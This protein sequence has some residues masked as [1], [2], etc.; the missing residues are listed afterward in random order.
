LVY[1][2]DD[3]P[4]LAMKVSLLLRTKWKTLLCEKFS[5]LSTYKQPTLLA[6]PFTS[7][8]IIA[9]EIPWV[10]NGILKNLYTSRFGLKRLAVNRR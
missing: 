7:D 10:E 4:P 9:E 2:L 3:G 6:P 8:G 1:G 5:W